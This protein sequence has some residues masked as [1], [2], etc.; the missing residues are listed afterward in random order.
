M[1]PNNWDSLT[2]HLARVAAWHAARRRPLGRERADRADQRVP[3]ARRTA[4]PLPLRRD[5]STALF[6]LP[7]YVAQLAILAA[8]YGAARRLGFEPRAAACGSALVATFSLVALEATTAQNDLVA[9]SFPV[10]AAFLLLGAGRDRGV[11]RRRSRSLSA[12]A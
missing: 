8:V 9:A 4:D 7:Q 6:A 2:Y 5:G 1:P 3:A 11:P 10:A 12:S